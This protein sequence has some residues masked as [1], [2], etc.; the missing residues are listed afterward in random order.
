MLETIVSDL[1]QQLVRG[2]AAARGLDPGQIEAMLGEGPFP[3]E[4]AQ[5]LRLVDALGYRE[6]A[7]A[8]AR[9]RAGADARA[10]DLADYGRR[11]LPPAE[12]AARVALVEAAGPIVRGEAPF[13]LRI[14][15]ETLAGVMSGIA[16]DP[17]IDAVVLQVDSPGG[18][19][20]ASETVAHSIAALVG[21]G[22]PVVV[23]MGNAAASGGYWISMGASRIVAEPATLT[24]SI[25]VI[26]G[27]PVLT[28]LWE[29]LGVNWELVATAPHAGMWSV[30][31][32][33]TVEERE[34]VDRLVGE[35]YAD[36]KEGVVRSRNL[37]PDWVETVAR[38][39]VWNGAAAQ[40][41]GLVDRLGGL[42]EALD[43]TRGLLGLP[44]TAPLAVVKR[45]KPASPFERAFELVSRNLE[46]G[47]GFRIL[48]TRLVH[49]G[50][51]SI[52]A[53]HIR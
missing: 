5:T 34:R 33:F 47:A 7:L 39:R 21:T 53:P 14:G 20:V 27:K 31:R 32:P 43:E 42:V 38:G 46:L 24:G 26:A 51:A 11:Q 37:T 15:A 10:V 40:S 49:P 35:L 13:G 45:P 2:V 48:L 41:L 18:S 29:D 1:Q 30:N 8:L 44:A 19:A 6:D 12:A 50:V 25:G 3:A 16:V 9:S 28:E 23:S 17:E 52:E 22:K 36:F 4:Q